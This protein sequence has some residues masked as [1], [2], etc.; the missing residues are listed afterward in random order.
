MPHVNANKYNACVR[1]RLPFLQI[2]GQY[3][4][5]KVVC[6]PLM[7]AVVPLRQ[8]MLAVKGQTIILAYSWICQ[9]QMHC[10]DNSIVKALKAKQY[11]NTAACMHAWSRPANEVDEASEGSGSIAQSDIKS[12]SFKCL[13]LNE[14]CLDSER[15]FAD[16]SEE[17]IHP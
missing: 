9:I 14:T 15:P 4:R 13:K 8:E 3:N 10:T 7:N 16:H 12:V 5:I 6:R 1:S 11:L 17:S 2:Q